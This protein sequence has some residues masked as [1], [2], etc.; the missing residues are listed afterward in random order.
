MKATLI[1]AL[2]LVIGIYLLALDAGQ[3]SAGSV[4]YIKDRTLFVEAAE[5]IGIHGIT[6][7]DYSSTRARLAGFGLKLGD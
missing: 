7:K 3:V 2:F 6:H 1:R 5:S 4:F